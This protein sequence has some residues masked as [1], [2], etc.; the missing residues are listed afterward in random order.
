MRSHIKL[1]ISI[2]QHDHDQTKTGGSHHQYIHPHNMI[3]K[4]KNEN[5]Y[6]GKMKHMY[7][8]N[9]VGSVLNVNRKKE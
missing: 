4:A 9:V 1:Y 3:Y 2:M 7:T 6:E 8:I 5:E